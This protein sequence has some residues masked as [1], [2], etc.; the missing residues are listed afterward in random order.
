MEQ[1]RERERQLYRLQA[2]LCQVLAD[3]TRLELLH[4]LGE[5]PRVVKE[6]VE[7]TGQR[8]AKISQHLAVLRQHHIVHTQRIGTEIRYSLTTPRI[9]EACRITHE[10]L[11][12]QLEQQSRRAALLVPAKEE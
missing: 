10:I 6:L 1:E 8:Q 4:L 7:A 12:Q 9:L 3:P 11:L 5:R 2:E